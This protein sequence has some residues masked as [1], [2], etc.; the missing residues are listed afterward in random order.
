MSWNI[1]KA[2]RNMIVY[3]EDIRKENGEVVEYDLVGYFRSGTGQ[4]ERIQDRFVPEHI[5]HEAQ[6]TALMDTR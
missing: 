1:R 4:Y 5:F 3:V 6:L 2:K